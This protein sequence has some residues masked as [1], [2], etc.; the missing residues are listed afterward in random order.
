MKTHPA[1]IVFTENERVDGPKRWQGRLLLKS[2]CI[3]T[4]TGRPVTWEPIFDIEERQDG[5]YHVAMQGGPDKGGRRYTTL[6]SLTAAQEH[7]IR[8]AGR[9]F[10]IPAEERSMPDWGPSASNQDFWAKK[11]EEDRQAKERTE[12][13]LLNFLSMLGPIGGLR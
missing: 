8:W 5:R 3:D 1:S 4:E 10:R 6:P 12:R 13:G 2:V 9:R 11:R 7:G